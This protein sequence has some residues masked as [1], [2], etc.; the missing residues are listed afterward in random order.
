MDSLDA[1]KSLKVIKQFTD[2]QDEDHKQ[3]TT[4]MVTLSDPI[5]KNSF[6]LSSLGAVLP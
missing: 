6:N 1:D 2:P 4:P 5:A 3:D